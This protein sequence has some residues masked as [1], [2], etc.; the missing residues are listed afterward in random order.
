MSRGGTLLAVDPND[1]DHAVEGDL[2]AKV[3]KDGIVAR[4]AYNVFRDR[5]SEKTLAQYAEICGVSQDAI[6]DMAR[7]FTSYGKQAAAEFYRGAVQHTDGYYNGQAIILLN[8]L[9]GNSG[10][11]GGLAQG[12]GHWHEFGGAPGNPYNFKEMHPAPHWD[13]GVKAES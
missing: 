12:G 13:F 10:W 2:E 7:Q 4:T 8:V 9:I 6:V 11:K 5:V 3:E 1:K